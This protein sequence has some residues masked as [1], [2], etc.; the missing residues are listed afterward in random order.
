MGHSLFDLTR[1]ETG[2]R[3]LMA[4]SHRS[5]MIRLN[6]PR[7]QNQSRSL[8]S[9][10]CNSRP[11]EGRLRSRVFTSMGTVNHT[12][13]LVG[14]AQKLIPMLPRK[15][16]RRSAKRSKPEDTTTDESDPRDASYKPDESDESDK[17]GE[18]KGQIVIHGCTRH[19]GGFAFVVSFGRDPLIFTVLP[20]KFP[21]KYTSDLIDYYESHLDFE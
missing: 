21:S 20:D 9:L 15:L 10:G 18:A 14:W 7:K 11:L 3:S 16:R 19:P 1:F 8:S 5:I 13:H 4:D 2:K 6:A 17:A 12:K